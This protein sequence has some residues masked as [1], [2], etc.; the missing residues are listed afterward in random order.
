MMALRFPKTRLDAPVAT[1][2]TM[3]GVARFFSSLWNET[4]RAL[5]IL[6]Q[7]AGAAIGITR[8]PADKPVEE[9]HRALD[10][11]HHPFGSKSEAGSGAGHKSKNRGNRP[12]ASGI[13]VS[14]RKGRIPQILLHIPSLWLFAA[15]ATLVLLE[16]PSTSGRFLDRF[17]GDI[18]AGW[19]GQAVCLSLLVDAFRGVVPRGVA[20]IP[21][22]FYSSYYFAF[23]QQGNHIALK[24]EELRRTNP[25]NILQFDPSVY[26][27]VMDAADLFVASHSVSV[28]YSYDSTFFPAEYISYRL[29]ATNRIKSYLGRSPGN[30]Q[31]FSVYWDDI[32]Q[33]NVKE[34]KIPEEPRSR[35]ISVIIRDDPGEGWKDWN[36]GTRTT[37]LS[38]GGRVIGEFKSAYVLRLPAAPF[39]TI[40]CEFSASAGRRNCKAGF[41]TERM[42]IESRPNTVD[43]RLYDDPVSVMLQLKRRSRDEL[44][45]MQ[46]FDWGAASRS[47]PG[48]D[49]AFDALHDVIEGR[50]PALSYTTGLR[51]AGDSARLAPFAAGM[52]KRFLDLTQMETDFPGRRQQAALLALGVTA[53]G[54]AEFETVQGQLA[55]LVRNDSVR[56]EYPLLY[57]RLADAGPR[58]F[59]IYRDLFL[60]QNAT[61]S[62]K[63][64]AALA[65]CRIGQA[66]SELMS[67]MMSEWTGSDSGKAKDDNYSAALFVALAK[68][69]QDDAL[70]SSGRSGSRALQDWYDAV[71]AGR[72]RTNVGPNNCMPMEWPGDG[73]VPPFMAPRLR[74]TQQQW[75]IA[76]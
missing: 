36:I 75:R 4:V 27:L 34:L 6:R 76:E 30:A 53:L 50:S 11:F 56:N 66:D 69:G 32:L 54:P 55:D 21:I 20:L 48:E 42:S 45:D 47:A 51:I 33:A 23:W 13:S 29:I 44:A 2:L 15:L 68:L 41:K 3:A 31:V 7:S 74:W 70:R 64:L 62:D 8:R 28:V 52:A 5:E 39:F 61:Q 35:I 46:S 49:E 10:G 14:E 24:S 16:I 71:L 12:L 57:L 63:L 18:L 72:G 17:G 19:L 1:S 73:Y 65:I 37:T 58:L 59:S 38:M 26:S 43:H 60:A 67:A 22:M 40:G 25:A 9:V